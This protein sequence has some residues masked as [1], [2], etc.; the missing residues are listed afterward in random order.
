[1]KFK[2]KMLHARIS[3]LVVTKAILVEVELVFFVVLEL[4]EEDKLEPI[5]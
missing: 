1:M 2:L 5:A 3:N 4:M